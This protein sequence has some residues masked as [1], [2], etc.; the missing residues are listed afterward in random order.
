M[1]GGKGT[2]EGQVIIITG[3]GTG[4]GR[5]MAFRLA[6]EGADIVV[7]A[8]RVPPLEETAAGVRQRGRKALAVSTDV[9][10]TTQVN[11]LIEKTLAAMGHIDVLINN[12]GI[13]R[14]ERPKA[15]WEISDEDWRT[16]IDV[17]LSSAFY[18]SRAISKYF[19]DRKRGKI[20]LVA[21]GEGFR[22]QRNS[23]MYNTAKAGV[24]NLTRVMAL[25]L[26]EYNVRVN[27]IVPGF[28]DT[29]ENQPED[30]QKIMAERR[31]ARKLF[32]PVGNPGKPDDIGYVALFL[33]S[34]ASDYVT[35]G[36]F[37]S[38]GGGLA[39]GFAITGY[40]PVVS[41]KEGRV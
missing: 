1:N 36:C 33:C 10:D 8:R 5:S 9:T 32:V 38:D 19:A 18:C 7:A 29:Y 31:A 2:L 35:G 12:A 13:V 14:G 41:L 23:F 20:I 39:G 4:L 25:T 30:Y 6:E 27:C 22:G 40:A 37:I 24:V 3:G 11:G 21:S 15:L 34:D 17:N 28:V 16:G 26:A